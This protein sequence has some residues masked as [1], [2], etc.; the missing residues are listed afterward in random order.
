MRVKTFIP[1]ISWNLKSAEVT[2][3][4]FVTKR[5]AILS[6]HLEA[7][8]NSAPTKWGSTSFANLV[9]EPPGG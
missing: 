5:S 1:F 8:S 3:D 4:D 9:S 6:L 2:F 7:L